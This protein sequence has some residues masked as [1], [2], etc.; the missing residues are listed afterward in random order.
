MDDRPSPG[1]SFSRFYDI[2]ERKWSD[3][4]I[5]LTYRYIGSLISFVFWFGFQRKDPISVFILS[6]L[7]SRNSAAYYM[8][9]LSKLFSTIQCKRVS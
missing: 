5:G 8:K 3:L 1:E 4:F 6:M 7:Q 2:H 9:A